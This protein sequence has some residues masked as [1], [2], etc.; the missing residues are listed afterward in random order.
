[1][2]STFPSSNINIRIEEMLVDCTQ[3]EMARSVDNMKDKIRGMVVIIID[4]CLP[5][6]NIYTTG[7]RIKRL[8]NR[9]HT[10]SHLGR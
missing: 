10:I 5:Q 8:S 9:S 6:C 3:L 4:L 1:M 2:D 7:F